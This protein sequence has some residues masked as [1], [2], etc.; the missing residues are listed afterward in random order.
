[1]ATRTWWLSL[2]ITWSFSSFTGNIVSSSLAYV[3][4]GARVPL[5]KITDRGLCSRRDLKAK[6]GL[7]HQSES[8]LL[9]YVP[10][11]SSLMHM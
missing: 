8:F 5:V 9:F 4:K 7:K 1:M 3:F 11:V 6:D 10:I 2:G